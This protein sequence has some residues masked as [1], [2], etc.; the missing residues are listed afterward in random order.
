MENRR[1]LAC[2]EGR[3][4]ADAEKAFNE[5]RARVGDKFEYF[6]AYDDSIYD[7]RNKTMPSPYKD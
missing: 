5:M 2:D 7:L 6:T 1:M 4:L 3:I